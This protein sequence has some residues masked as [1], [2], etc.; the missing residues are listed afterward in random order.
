MLSLGSK[1]TFPI[2]DVQNAQSVIPKCIYDSE[3][4]D[5][6]EGSHDVEYAV[7]AF[8]GVIFFLF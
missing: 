3:L 7:D 2:L 8:V 1:V 6:T 5:G 4:G